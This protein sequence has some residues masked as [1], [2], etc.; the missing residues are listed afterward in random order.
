M[1]STGAPRLVS[2]DRERVR[3]VPLALDQ[4]LAAD[5]PARLVWEFV[6]GLDLSEQLERIRAREGHVGRPAIDPRTLLCLWLYAT[7]EGVGSARHIERLCREHLAFIWICGGASVGHTVL[8]EFRVGD[9]AGLDRILTGCV[10]S[11]VHEGLVT[12]KRVAQDGIRV[13]ASAGAASMHRKRTLEDRLAEAEAQVSA[14]KAEMEKDP[15]SSERR[16]TAAKARGAE[17]R[18]KKLKEAL[19][20]LPHVQQV[21][22]RNR[23]KK[24]R[25]AARK[26]E[27]RASAATDDAPPATEQ[28]AAAAASDPDVVE[29]RVSS[30]D[31]DARVMKMADGGYRPAL[32]GQFATDV[33]SLVVVSVDVINT[34]ADAGQHLAAIDNVQKVYGITPDEWL[35]DGGFPT[36]DSVEKMP[37]GCDLIAPLPPNKDPN[38]DPFKR[39][40]KDSDK[41]AAWRERMGTA[42]AQ[43]TYRRRAAT[44]ELVNAHARNRGLRQ[45]QVRGVHNARCVMLMHAIVNNIVR[46]AT[47]RA[48]EGAAV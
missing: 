26:A 13:R 25:K 4:L 34:G 33:D 39:L 44:A 35:V 3:L 43:D 32:N 30:T 19:R 5:H 1:A 16:A 2:P 29:A 41:V 22:E 17:A 15:S 28:A 11:L 46:G 18:Q 20:Q 14:L 7:L 36:L 21:Q 8:A 31:P 6:E 48:K 24:A 37:D 9:E 23:K 40:P 12:M 45:F 10:A 38:R 27:K 47:L 42:K